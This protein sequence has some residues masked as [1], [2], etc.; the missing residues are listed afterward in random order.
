MYPVKEATNE[1]ATDKRYY[2]EYYPDAEVLCKTHRNPVPP[3][4]EELRQERHRVTDGSP[5]ADFYQ[6]LQPGLHATTEGSG[7]LSPQ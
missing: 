7:S 6:A 3:V 2:G 5:N 1:I 4:D